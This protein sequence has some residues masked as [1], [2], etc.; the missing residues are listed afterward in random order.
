MP[1]TLTPSLFYSIVKKASVGM[2]G[3]TDVA[4]LKKYAV[5][6]K[7]MRMQNLFIY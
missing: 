6:G 5:I 2:V 1:C 4:E 7:N 3:M